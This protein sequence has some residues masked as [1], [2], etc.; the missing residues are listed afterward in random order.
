MENNGI[1]I[2]VEKTDNKI[3][4]VVYEL[5]NKAQNLSQKLNGAKIMAVLPCANDETENLL[6]QIKNN[7]FDE[8]FIIKNQ[9]LKEYSTDN[10]S[11]VIIDLIKE[12]QPSIFL[13][14]ATTQGRDLAPRISSNLNTGLTADCTELDINENGLLAATRP[15]FGGNLMATILCKTTPQMATVRPN[16]LTINEE[17]YN[18]NTNIEYLEPNIENDF[19]RTKIL[20]FIKNNQISGINLNEAEIIIAGGKGLKNNEGFQLIKE[21][22][23]LLNASVGASRKAVDMG[24]ATKDMQI[25]QTGKTVTPK[26]YI[27]IGISGAIQHIVGMSGSK[28]IIAIN[29]DKDANI[30]KIADYSIVADAFEL[31][32]EWINSLK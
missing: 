14:G 32:P 28:K 21:L 10:Y 26:L 6:A 22:A 2:Y 29:K 25:G 27:A 13:I 23:K 11:K 15:T 17:F 16:V 7:Y 1:L 4:P 31:L 3:A 30:F 19:S 5:A 18:K 9:N 24:L 8:I 12:K 20:D